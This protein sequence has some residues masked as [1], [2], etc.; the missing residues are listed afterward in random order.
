MLGFVR[1]VAN[2]FNVGPG[3]VQIGV[4]T[5][6]TTY[7][8]EFNL[9]AF[10]DKQRM[11]SAIN[12]IKY[13]QGLTHTGEAIRFMTTDSFTAAHGES[14]Y[15]TC[16]FMHYHSL[17]PEESIENGGRK[18]RFLLPTDAFSLQHWFLTLPSMKNHIRLVLIQ[19]IPAKTRPGSRPQRAGGALDSSWG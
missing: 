15:Q 18:P 12:N 3:D 17:G 8:S 5:F 2:S 7:K 19:R 9:N 11:L 13:T 14:V 10:T 4:D 1:N 16:L 6:Q